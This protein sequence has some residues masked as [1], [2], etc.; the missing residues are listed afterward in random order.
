MSNTNTLNAPLAMVGDFEV[1]ALSDGLLQ[2]S[3]DVVLKL[4]R[5]QKER[6]SGKKVGDP[7]HISVNA[8]L[9]KRNGTYALIDTGSGNT[10]GPTLGKL[11]A[12]LRA[13]GVE[14]EAIGTIFLT[15][16][17]SDHSNGL[18]DDEGRAIYPNA[19][20]ILHEQE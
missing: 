17:H 14:P 4:D 13:A 11:P 15:H 12:N 2:T 3:L 10:M 5:A 1:I 8:F 6:L 18:I 20:L 7:V 16:L 19:E 9:L